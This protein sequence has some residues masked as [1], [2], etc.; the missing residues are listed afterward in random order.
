MKKPLSIR[1]LSPSHQ[2]GWIMLEVIICLALFAVVLHLAQ[3]QNQVQWHAIQQIETQRNQQENQQKQAAMV[4]L[5]GSSSWLS[6]QGQKAYP[7]CQTCAGSQLEDWFY[8]ALHPVS[9]TSLGGEE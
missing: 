6:D 9:N 8:G 1:F 2:R 7:D 5:T 4:V 3:R